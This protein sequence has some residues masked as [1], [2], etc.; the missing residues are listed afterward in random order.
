MARASRGAENEGP[1]RNAHPVLACAVEEDKRL[2]MKRTTSK[3]QTGDQTAG[4]TA[5][6]RSR[7]KPRYQKLADG[8]IADI[9]AG[10][11]PVGSL[12]PGELELRARD[13]VS[14]HTARE[15]LR[16]LEELGYVARRPGIGTRV[17]SANPAR[18]YVQ[19]HNNSA[20]LLSYVRDTDFR[21]I[22]H[23]DVI[24]DAQLVEQIGGDFGATWLEITGYRYG[25]D[26]ALPMAYSVVHVAD[27]Y[28]E[29]SDR[30][31]D[32]SIPIYTQIEEHFGIRAVELRQKIAACLIEGEDADRLQVAPGSPGLLIERRYVDQTGAE[33]EIAHSLHV[34]SRF[35]YKVT[36]RLGGGGG[37]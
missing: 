29:V 19:V 21:P 13:D 11:Y 23:R 5:T 30:L 34:A 10:R 3:S 14:R 20:D 27:K 26:D 24:A 15:A 22:G 8:L 28:R 9:Q 6:G 35:S 31:Q 25:P 1:N 7:T 2:A 4:S 18:H 17:L 36:L 37:S 16:N 33:F 32:F 12:L